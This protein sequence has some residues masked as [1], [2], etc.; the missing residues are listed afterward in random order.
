MLSIQLNRCSKSFK[1]NFQALFTES[2]YPVSLYNMLM[3]LAGIQ[4]ANYCLLMTSVLTE[5][6]SYQVSGMMI[7]KLVKATYTYH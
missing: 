2:L 5:L 1:T 3:P 7:P 6:F 4:T